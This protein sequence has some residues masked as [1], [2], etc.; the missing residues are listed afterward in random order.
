MK[1]KTITAKG[2]ANMPVLAISDAKFMDSFESIR[3]NLLL[4]GFTQIGAFSHFSYKKAIEK[5]IVKAWYW[6]GEWS[7]KKKETY[8]IFYKY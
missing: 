5:T 3:T 8:A 6:R 1:T 7:G 4:N 2:W